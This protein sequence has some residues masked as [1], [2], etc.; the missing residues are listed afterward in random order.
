MA[1]TAC[2]QNPAMTMLLQ[3]PDMQLAIGGAANMTVS[4]LGRLASALG[5]AEGLIQ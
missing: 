5:A 2:R 4:W 1:A 3:E